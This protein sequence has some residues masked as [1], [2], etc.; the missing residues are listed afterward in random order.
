MNYYYNIA[1]DDVRGA[2]SKLRILNAHI[3]YHKQIG[4][5]V[6]PRLRVNNKDIWKEYFVGDFDYSVYDS[7]QELF[8]KDVK[9]A[10]SATT[11]PKNIQ[12]NDA[13]MSKVDE[14]YKNIGSPTIAFYS[15]ETDKMSEDM[16]LA[17]HFYSKIIKNEDIKEPIMMVSDCNYSINYLK[18]KH[19]NIFTMPH[20][21]SDNFM[22]MHRFHKNRFN[23]N[24]SVDELTLT[25]QLMIDVALICKVKKIYYGTWAGVLSM[26]HCF[27]PDDTRPK[28]VDIRTYVDVDLMQVLNYYKDRETF[29]WN[30][31][32]DY[33]WQYNEN[34]I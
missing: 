25:H 1:N 29:L 22:P 16:V 6:Y 24:K 13:W 20:H 7:C 14:L 26:T 27:L 18:S 28:L 21:R 5:V 2:C 30:V 4:N 23:N 9:V 31:I 11:F 10:E 34:I 12:F 3:D 8:C 19:N 33:Y 15:R 17:P 32:Q